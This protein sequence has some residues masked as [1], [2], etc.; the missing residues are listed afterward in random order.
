MKVLF[1]CGLNEDGQCGIP[2]KKEKEVGIPQII[3]FATKVQIIGISAGSRHSLALSNEGHVYSWGWGL[4]GQLGHGNSINLSHPLRIP[5][6]SD[7]T[8]IS[9][10]GMH[11]GC[12]SATK[13]CYMWGDNSQGQLGIGNKETTAIDEPTPLCFEDGE[14]FQVNK[15][16]CGGM[17][18]AAVSVKG[19]VFCWGKSD[20]GQTGFTTWYLGLSTNIYFPKKVEGLNNVIDVSCGGFYTLVLTASGQVFAMGKEDYGCL[21]TGMEEG[22]FNMKREGPTQV[23]SLQDVCIKQISAGGWHSCFLTDDGRLFTCGKGEYGRLGLGEEA[24][25][26]FPTE[27]TQDSKRQNVK[28]VVQVSAGGSHTIW[29]NRNNRVHAVG[30][31][32]GGRCGTGSTANGRLALSE[33]ITPN[34]PIQDFLVLEVAAGGSHTLILAE[35]S[36]PID[37]QA[38]IFVSSPNFQKGPGGIPKLPSFA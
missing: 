25:K 11:S 18:S 16:S 10:G 34:F 3:K 33:D 37:E 9:A 20:S 29:F 22:A 23:T 15:L 31:L 6:L 21:G 12:V 1:G 19:F 14:T 17:H 36:Q 26:L 5:S 28:D 32:D 7:I 35:T 27:M 13:I 38:L 30:R 8:A 4:A 2:V 24:S